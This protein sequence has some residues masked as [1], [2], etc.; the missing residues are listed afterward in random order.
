[1]SLRSGTMQESSGRPVSFAELHACVMQATELDHLG[2]RPK[3]ERL[4]QVKSC[5]ELNELHKTTVSSAAD[6][7]EQAGYPLEQWSVITP[8]GYVLV[9]ERMPR[10]GGHSSVHDSCSAPHCEALHGLSAAVPCAG[11]VCDW[12]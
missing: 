10:K 11:Q 5:E 7:I 1:M 9:M 2:M 12:G 6:I 8:D 4:R 3:T